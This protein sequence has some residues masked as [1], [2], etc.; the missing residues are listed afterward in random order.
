MP[1]LLLFVVEFI[2]VSNIHFRIQ[3]SPAKVHKAAHP[4]AFSVLY[5]LFPSWHVLCFIP[6]VRENFPGKQIKTSTKEFTMIPILPILTGTSAV[7]SIIKNLSD[8]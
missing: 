3:Q 8:I 5:P 2:F 6:Y 4:A 1:G 7:I